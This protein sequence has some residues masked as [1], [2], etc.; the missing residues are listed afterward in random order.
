VEQTDRPSGEDGESPYLFG[1]LLALARANWVRKM[2]EGLADLGYLDYRRTDA[3]LLRLLRRRGPVAI[4]TIG[5]RLGISRQ[6]ARKLVDG[7]KQRGYCSEARDENDGRVVKVT[8]T[9][10]GSA[11][12]AAVTE[13]VHRLNRE[14][15]GRVSH[16]QLVAADA[17]LRATFG[18]NAPAVAARLPPPRSSTRTD[19]ELIRSRIKRKR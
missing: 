8:L 12:A 2:A 11:Y 19:T 13:V 15:V 7:L 5:T 1:D 17:V 4:G 3:A 16:D 18:D 6:A 9:P 10:T 14:L